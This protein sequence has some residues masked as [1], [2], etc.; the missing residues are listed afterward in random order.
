MHFYYVEIYCH[1]QEISPPLHLVDMK[2]RN[3]FCLAVP[4]HNLKAAKDFYG[5][6]Q[7]TRR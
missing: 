6:L 2:R 5:E 1:W 7:I 4:V 3:H